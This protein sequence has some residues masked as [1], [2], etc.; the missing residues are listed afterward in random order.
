MVDA[1][2]VFVARINLSRTW[3]P[4]SFESM[5]WNVC[6]HRLGLGLYSY[7]RVLGNGVRIHVNSWGKSVLP[8]AQ[9]R[10]KPTSHPINSQ[11][12]ESNLGD[13]IKNLNVGSH[14]DISRPNSFFFFFFSFFFF[15]VPGHA[16]SSVQWVRGSLQSAA[17]SQP[18]P[19]A[20][21]GHTQD[22]AMSG[23][24]RV[25]LRVC[26]P[27]RHGHSSEWEIFSLRRWE[28][29]WQ[30]PVLSLKIVTWDKLT[31]SA[32][33]LDA[34]LFCMSRHRRHPALKLF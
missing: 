8:E 21:C 2:C 19:K 24:C 28:R 34:F 18:V 5:Q 4:W 33:L 11:G 14:S 6:V 13:F 29:S 17:V 20:S 25:W 15:C 9:R 12:R 10:V 32:Q 27:V 31:C 1:A 22:W 26:R 3:M 30:C 7:P 16:R 23:I